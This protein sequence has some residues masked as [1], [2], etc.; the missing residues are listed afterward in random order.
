M[1]SLS[2][3]FICFPAEMPLL[4]P[5]SAS[6]D[7]YFVS[8]FSCFPVS[9]SPFQFSFLFCFAAFPWLQSQGTLFLG[10]SDFNLRNFENRFPPLSVAS[11]LSLVSTPCCCPHACRPPD[12]FR[13]EF[14]CSRLVIMRVRFSRRL[15][16]LAVFSRF[17]GLLHLALF[18]YRLI[19]SR[20]HFA[21][22]SRSTLI[23][24]YLWSNVCIEAVD[25][26]E[27]DVIFVF[28]CSSMHNRYKST[29]ARMTSHCLHLSTRCMGF[30]R[31]LT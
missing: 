28:R 17:C 22:P 21:K 14:Q 27:E 4:H 9:C 11:T 6:V 30:N 24:F 16:P 20:L 19:F 18:I 13:F 1:F 26:N 7:A 5:S 8:R 12:N 31:W 15:S 23:N 2:L 25:R 3:E 10:M 29:R